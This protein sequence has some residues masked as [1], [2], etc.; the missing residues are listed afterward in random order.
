MEKTYTSIRIYSRD[1]GTNRIVGTL[2]EAKE[3][4]TLGNSC[5]NLDSCKIQKNNIF[6]F[7]KNFNY[8]KWIKFEKEKNSR[9]L[10]YRLMKLRT[11]LILAKRYKELQ[12]LQLCKLLSG[13]PFYLKCVIW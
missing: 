13:D 3:T 2:D 4:V 8:S 9:G 10:Y 5:L 6:D 1:E 11:L 7:R 12:R